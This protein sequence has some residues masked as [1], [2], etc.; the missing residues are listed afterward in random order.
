MFYIEI[1]YLLNNERLEVESNKYRMGNP[2]LVELFNSIL[3]DYFC[4]L[5]ALQP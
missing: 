5:H 2:S 3:S 1:I 4:S